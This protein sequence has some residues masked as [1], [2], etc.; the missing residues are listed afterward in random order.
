[1][2]DWG[3]IIIDG[4]FSEG[5]NFIKIIINRIKYRK[6]R[7]EL[8]KELE[9]EFLKKYQGEAYY[10]DLDSFLYTNKIIKGLLRNCYETSPWNYTY[11][12]Q[13]IV[14]YATLFIQKYPKH[15]F[16]KGEIEVI[17]KKFFNII[18]KNLNR[19]NDNDTIRIIINNTK[20]IFGSLQND[21]QKLD[22]QF[23]VF[24]DSVDNK[25]NTIIEKISVFNPNFDSQEFSDQL[26]CYYKLL[27]NNCL[28]E[29]E[30]FERSI[31]VKKDELT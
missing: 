28:L 29:N 17:L 21:V 18:F 4:I 6:L 24:Q 19:Y 27:Q 30:Y 22:S 11:S 14:Y 10:N 7:E 15:K 12:S 16:R 13:F 3:N 1:M 8:Q 2:S 26:I 9:E 20:E 25:L 23:H 5:S 31:Y